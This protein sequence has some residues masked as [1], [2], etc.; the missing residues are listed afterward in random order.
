MDSQP[1]PIDGYGFMLFINDYLMMDMGLYKVVFH[2][3]M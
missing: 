2:R 1:S 3:S